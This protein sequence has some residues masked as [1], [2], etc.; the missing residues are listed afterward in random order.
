[1]NQQTAKRRNDALMCD[2]DVI[3]TR[4]FERVAERQQRREGAE[5]GHRH[6]A[7]AAFAK[8]SEHEREQETMDIAV[9]YYYLALGD[10]SRSIARLLEAARRDSW[11]RGSPGREGHSFRSQV[12]RMNDFDRLRSHPRFVELVTEPEEAAGL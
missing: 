6:E 10:R 5:Q 3:P 8:L 2:D 4:R 7:R 9:A 11:L 12:Y 1:M